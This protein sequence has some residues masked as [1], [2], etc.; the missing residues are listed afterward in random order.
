MPLPDA[1]IERE[2][3]H[4]RTVKIDGYRRADGLW[5]IDGWMTDVKTISFPNRD[6]GEIKAGEP[7]HGMGLRITIDDDLKIVDAVAVTDFSP[8]A[9]CPNITP[10]FKRLI[11]MRIKPGFTTA[12]KQALG[13]TEGCVHLVELL[14][15]IATTAFQT[16]AGQ[17]FARMNAAP[18]GSSARRPPMLDTCHAWASDGPLVKR[19]YPDFYKDPAAQTAA[20]EKVSG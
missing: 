10:N 15:P 20:R 9:I 2:R 18:A 6:R 11:G 1:S 5:D 16:L 17:R 12:V 4:T 13:G 3:L 14:G 19:D 7:L 8:F